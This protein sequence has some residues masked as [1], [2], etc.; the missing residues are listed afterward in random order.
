MSLQFNREVDKLK[1]R[2]LKLSS[3]VEQ[4]VSQAVTAIK[5]GDESLA[6]SVISGDSEIDQMEV[7]I[8]EDC[9]KI[10]ALYQPVAKD[11]RFIV[12]AL[13]MNNDL[14]RIGDLAVK[15]AKHA[16]NIN[17]NI[18]IALTPDYIDMAGDVEVMLKKSIDCVVNMDA[19]LAEQVRRMDDNIDR[20]NRE[21][22]KQIIS[23][24]TKSPQDA[25]NFIQVLGV[26]RYLERI[27]DHAVNIAEDVIY[28]TKGK[29]LRHS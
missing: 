25:D 9:L 22:R 6:E 7:D 8:E 23:N 18:K 11:L 19:V 10:L 21:I 2:L 20:L 24:I 14:E 29:I 27:A 5:K 1:S 4:A 3:L 26:P 16:A 15:I 12:S 17:P 28:I 13:K